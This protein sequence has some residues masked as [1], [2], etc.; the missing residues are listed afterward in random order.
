MCLNIFFII[1]KIHIS[2]IIN[3]YILKKNN[4]LLS[5]YQII[6]Y[7]HSIIIIIFTN[8]IYFNN[9]T[10]TNQHIILKTSPNQFFLIQIY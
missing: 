6:S 5:K 2:K 9:L 3:K 7:N 8:P 1:I 10:K 4:F